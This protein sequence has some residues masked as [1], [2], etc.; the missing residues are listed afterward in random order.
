MMP[1]IQ[2][3]NVINMVI[4]SGYTG[5]NGNNLLGVVNGLI[6]ANGV[7]GEKAEQMKYDILSE[8]RK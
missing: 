6:A 7:T 5:L 3:A 8:V 1:T 4:D 2:A